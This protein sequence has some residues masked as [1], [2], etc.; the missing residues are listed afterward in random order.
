MHNG[1]IMAL[2]DLYDSEASV[3]IRWYLMHATCIGLYG[4][5]IV[6]GIKLAAKFFTLMVNTG[7]AHLHVNWKLKQIELDYI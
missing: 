4:I 2:Y 3:I 5:I 6:L 1:V 7:H